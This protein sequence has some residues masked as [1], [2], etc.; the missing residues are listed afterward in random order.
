MKTAEQILNEKERPMLTVSPETHLYDALKTMVEYQTGAIVV[1]DKGNVI[2]IWTE[3][4]LM[5]DSLIENFD[6]HK[7][8]MADHMSTQLHKVA[9]DEPIYKLP[10]KMLGLYI[11][12]LFVEK[13]GQIIGI[14]SS[15]DVLRACLME[16][17]RQLKSISWDYYEN[18]GWNEKGK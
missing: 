3:R 4:D 13:E 15:G 17:T 18:W 14:L 8:K 16:R 5:A 10:D 9:Y 11:R 7:A 12:H 1:Q 6:L 2:G